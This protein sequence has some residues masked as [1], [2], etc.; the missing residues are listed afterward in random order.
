MSRK[1]KYSYTTD[2]I[3]PLTQNLIG[4]VS[5]GVLVYIGLLGLNI[6]SG[7]II[8]LVAA[9][10]V[11]LVFNILRFF[12]DELDTIYRMYN[13]VEEELQTIND[14][15]AYKKNAELIIVAHYDKKMGI[16]ETQVKEVLGMNRNTYQ[17]ARDYLIQKSVL[18]NKYANKLWPTT[19]GL[20]LYKLNEV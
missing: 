8:S 3:I 18:K 7:L 6:S 13:G 10:V 11:F 4:G 20:A 19:K 5:F 14:S 15:S 16:S 2:I 12:L 1:N 17:K 9:G